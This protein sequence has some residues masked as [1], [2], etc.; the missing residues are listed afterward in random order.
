[1]PKARLTLEN[2]TV[3]MESHSA[4][5]KSTP[6]PTAASAMRRR[7][8]LSEI[9]AANPDLALTGN[10]ISATFST[11]HT[12]RYLKGGDWVSFC[13]FPIPCECALGV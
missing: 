2:N 10:I 1:L 11:P 8:S 4:L 5:P 3:K 6:N 13:P 7:E 9:R 12:F